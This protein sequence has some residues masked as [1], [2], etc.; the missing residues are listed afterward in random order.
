MTYYKQNQRKNRMKKHIVR[1]LLSIGL[2]LV[3]AGC[4]DATTTVL[5]KKD[6]SGY[7]DDTM[8]MS[9]AASQ[10]IAGM[11]AGMGGG[12]GASAAGAGDMP[13]EPEKYKAKAL[14]MGEG[15]KY[16][17][18]KRMT[19][20]DGSKGVR[21]LYSFEDINKIKV[22]QNPDAPSG[23]GGPGGPGGRMQ[24]KDK[25]EKPESP[26]TFSFVPGNTAKLTIN[27]PPPDKSEPEKMP[28][29]EEGSG[30][31]MGGGMPGGEQMMN[32]MFTGMRIR[33]MVKVDGEITD[34]NGSYVHSGVKSGKK[35][36]LTLFDMDIGKL[37][38]NPE[39]MKKLQALGKNKDISAAKD[40]LKEIPGVKVETEQKI[41]VT[42]K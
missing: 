6:G 23:P 20:Q 22:S 30:M 29:R 9:A 35:C 11:M 4:F 21:V 33:L 17:S 13:L 3:G 42:F 7:I 18:A 39:H 37:L 36:Y 8:Y 10:M 14:K 38:G 34:T 32:A 15:V 40:A 25:E 31:N 26:I 41:E 27:M 5:I 24:P 19:K 2:L 28:E 12:G 16:V 1:G